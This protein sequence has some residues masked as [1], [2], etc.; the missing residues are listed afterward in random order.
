MDV[1]ERDVPE[2][3]VLLLVGSLMLATAT[4]GATPTRSPQATPTAAPEPPPAFGRVV[5]RASKAAS[6][7]SLGVPVIACRHRDSEP[8]RIAV[9]FFDDL[10]KKVLVFGP[11]VTGS[12]PAGKKTVFVS[13]ALYYPHR[14][15]IN[16]SVAHF[17]NGTARV[18]SDARVIHCMAKMRFDPGALAPTYWRSM[19]LYRPD[20]GGTPVDVDW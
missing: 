15:V 7:E 20:A 2:R 12:V 6:Y 4:I 9:E 1:P 14:D 16:V 17:V 13:D 5:Y 10:G 3:R 8:R 19:G 11:S 18:V